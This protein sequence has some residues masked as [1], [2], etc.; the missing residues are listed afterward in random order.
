MQNILTFKQHASAGPDGKARYPLP[1]EGQP[2]NL[3]R[4]LGGKPSADAEEDSKQS[5]EVSKYWEPGW[6]LWSTKGY[7]GAKERM[8]MMRF[9]VQTQNRR[10]KQR[11][12]IMEEWVEYQ[13]YA[14]RRSSQIKERLEDPRRK[15]YGRLGPAAPFPDTSYVLPYLQKDGFDVC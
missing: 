5:N 13:E 4:V 2:S 12:K 14:E 7:A 8:E 11:Q 6:Y 9:D 15:L 3:P 1:P 10:A